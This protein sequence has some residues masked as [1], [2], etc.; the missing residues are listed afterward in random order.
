MIFFVVSLEV[1]RHPLIKQRF[2]SLY[3]CYISFLCINSAHIFQVIYPHHSKLSEKEV[4]LNNWVCSYVQDVWLTLWIVFYFFKVS[5]D[6]LCLPGLL[7]FGEFGS[8]GTKCHAFLQK[9]SICYL[10]FPDSNS[11]EFSL[12]LVCFLRWC[13]RSAD[14]NS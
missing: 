11:G 10:S 2:A 13:L 14:Q 6:H 12:D 5:G 4:S 3:L 7:F 8:N 9:T 1:Y